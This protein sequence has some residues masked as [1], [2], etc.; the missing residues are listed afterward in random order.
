MR[1][2]SAERAHR[3]A[4]QALRAAQ[5]AVAD[6]RE[7]RA[8]T[9][10]RLEGA[11]ER[12]SEE[13]RKIRDALGCAPE[14]CLALAELAAGAEL[15]ALEEADSQLLR[16]KAD[17]ERLGGVNLQA[18]DDLTGLSAAVRGHE[19]GE[20]RRRGG[21]RQAARRHSR[22]STPRAKPACRPPSTPST[23]TSAACSPRCSAA[24]RRGWR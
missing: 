9:E 12:R 15:P 5:A 23:P 3:E 24:A 13:A 16:L 11:R 19:Q 17:R 7:A 1:W 6:E 21:H 2:P 18:D 10:A 4:A 14:G 22:R 8:R 20:G